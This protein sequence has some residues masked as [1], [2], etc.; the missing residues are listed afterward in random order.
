MAKKRIFI[1][2]VHLGAG[3]FS[4][5]SQDTQRYP[6]EWDWL[7]QVETENFELFLRYL[8]TEYSNQ[9]K[10][11]VLLGDIFDNWVFPHDMVPPTMD[12]LINADKNSNVV[13][14]LQVLSETLPLFY[15]PGNH[16]MHAT[17]AVMK[18]HFPLIT[19]CGERFNAS[20]LLAE[21]GHRYAL[22]NA[23]ARFSNNYM[24][25]P[26]GYFISR[27]EATKKAVTGQ[28]IRKYQTY[29]DD[30]LEM[31]GRPTLPQCVFEAVIEEAELDETLE[32][33]LMQFERR[34]LEHLSR[35]SKRIFTRTSMKI[36]RTRSFRG[37]GRFLPN[38]TCWVP[39]ADKL[40]KNGKF[41]VV[42]FSHS[43][44]C[45][46]DKDTWFVDDRIYANTG[47]WCGSRCTFVETEKTTNRHR[48][49]TVQWMGGNR[50]VKGKPYV[51]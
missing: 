23:P 21:H 45:E 48:V 18:R 38:W 32:F 36:G 8:R 43:H 7:S 10:E 50:I 33:K 41:N 27:I 15:V 25:L 28:Q 14:E 13:R 47:F 44:K 11:I 31:V 5:E 37:T 16:D 42:I 20:R 46:I 3:R 34:Q 17:K 49:R 26:L 35:K 2:D 30:F 9:I 19:Y 1:S 24:G 22:F 40:C 29:V 6:F 51:I 12:Q 4:D 39:V